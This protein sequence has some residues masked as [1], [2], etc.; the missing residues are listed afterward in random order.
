MK[1]YF[2]KVLWFLFGFLIFIII[3]GFAYHAGNV[4]DHSNK[5]GSNGIALIGGIIFILWALILGFLSARKNKYNWPFIIG[6][7]LAYII[8]SASL[9]PI[10][11]T[12]FIFSLWNA[13]FRDKHITSDCNSKR[14]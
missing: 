10:L 4:V 2:K 12:L 11:I 8:A 14:S 6:S 13:V 9:K 7:T 1:L 5:A 3:E